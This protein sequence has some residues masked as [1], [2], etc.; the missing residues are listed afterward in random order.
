MTESFYAFFKHWCFNFLKVSSSCFLAT[1]CWRTHACTVF[2]LEWLLLLSFSMHE[3]YLLNPTCSILFSCKVESCYF[4]AARLIPAFLQQ[5]RNS[6]FSCSMVDS[7]I[8]IMAWLNLYTR[9]PLYNK[10]HYNCF[11]YNTNQGWTPN[12][13]LRLLFLYNLCILLLI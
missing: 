2:Q 10:V 6:L 3:S 13:C 7:D 12:Y 1:R 8:F 5:G 4:L 11:G 9:E